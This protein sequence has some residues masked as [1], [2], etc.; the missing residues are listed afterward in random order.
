MSR[1]QGKLI[2]GLWLLICSLIWSA[3]SMALSAPNKA[4]KSD[5]KTGVRESLTLVQNGIMYLRVSHP[6]LLNERA[7]KDCT[8]GLST[9]AILLG[10]VL[11]QSGNLVF[12]NLG[13]ISAK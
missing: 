12:Q 1:N 5:L 13:T 2:F 9:K 11:D 10:Q 3:P 6:G 4:I 7:K 8:S